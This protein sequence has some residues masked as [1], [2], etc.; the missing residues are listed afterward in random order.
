MPLEASKLLGYNRVVKRLLAV[1]FLSGAVVWAQQGLSYQQLRDMLQSSIEQGLQDREISK[2]L[3]SQ[4]LR[5][6]LSDALL[7]EFQGMGAG[8]RT[9]KVLRELQT[10]S[11]AMPAPRIVEANK[12]PGP[13]QPPP[14]SEEDQ[15]RIIAETRANALA[16]TDNLP[17]FV[18]LQVTRR[19]E[20]P[21]GLEMDWLKQDEVKT[22]VSYFDHHENYEVISVNN[23]VTQAKMHDLG[24]TT[25]TGE[26][27]SML[28]QLFDPRTDAQFG[29]ARHSLLRGRAVYVFTLRVTKSRSHWWL[30]S[31]S[32]AKTDRI[33]TGYSGLVYIDKETEQVLRIYTEAE[34]IPRD[35]GLQSA[36]SRLDY[37]YIEIGGQKFLLPLKA[38]MRL[39][40]GKLLARNDVEF[41]LYRK[42]SADATITFDEAEDLDPLLEE[43][44]DEQAAEQPAKPR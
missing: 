43:E 6:A 32:V 26:F 31:Q 24:G 14:P 38:R 16:Y 36:Q 13:D 44:S 27:G 34:N 40:Q 4:K 8:S 28:A 1:M 39:R 25:S 35:F 7:E 42:F 22:R 23:Q 29:W 9:L 3:K 11:R 41:R 12:P 37:D 5:F 20:D 30:G 33:I 17:D 18:C 21:S 2:Y 19:Y 15:A 10:R